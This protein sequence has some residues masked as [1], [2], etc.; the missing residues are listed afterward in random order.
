MKIRMPEVSQKK[1]R[2][3]LEGWHQ[4]LEYTRSGTQPRTMIAMKTKR[5]EEKKKERSGVGFIGFKE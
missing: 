2:G 3:Q 1:R 4:V 5:R